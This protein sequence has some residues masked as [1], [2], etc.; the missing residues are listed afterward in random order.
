M[1]FGARIIDTPG[2]K[3][4]GIINF[5]KNEIGDFFP[6]FFQNKNKCKFNNCLHIDEPNCF[7]K[8]LVSM[9]K[10]DISRYENYKQIIMEGDLKYR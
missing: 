1:D 4:F 9:N 5:R 3:G 10:I 6:E 8:E 2:I 7:I